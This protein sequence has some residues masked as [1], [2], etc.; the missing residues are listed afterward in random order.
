MSNKSKLTNN[1]KCLS[2]N[3]INDTEN[4]T[5]GIYSTTSTYEQT[6]INDDDFMT[7]TSSEEDISSDTNSDIPT[8]VASTESTYSIE[9]YTSTAITYDE[10]SYESFEDNTN[11]ITADGG[12]F[13]DKQY[14]ISITKNNNVTSNPENYISATSDATW[15]KFTNFQSL[16][17]YS[18]TYNFD[19]LNQYAYPTF[20]IDANTSENDR[21]CTITFKA[22]NDGTTNSLTYKITQPGKGTEPTPTPTPTNTYTISFYES[23]VDRYITN[24][25]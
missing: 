9:N 4:I 21:T 3:N 1:Y 18:S 5:N 17:N 7:G 14:C 16:S 6:D 11:V 23:C 12:T 8:T 25:S 19:N 22:K 13:I 10:T 15:C 20:N 2:D 24:I